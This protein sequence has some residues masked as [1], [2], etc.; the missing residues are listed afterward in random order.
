[1][2]HVG[3][4][5]ERSLQERSLRDAFADLFAR[6]AIAALG[7]RQSLESL[8]GGSSDPRVA[9]S[10]WDNCMQA[11]ICK[12]PAIAI[13]IIG[14]LII[15]SIVWCIAR[16]LCCGLSCCCECCYCLKC[17]GECCGCCDPPRGKRNKYLDEPFVPPHHEPNQA[18]HSQ[19]PMTPGLPTAPSPSVPQ[20]AVFDDGNKKDADALPAMPS[21]EDA[22]SQKVLVEEEPVEMEPLKKP[23]NVQN[24]NSFPMS[25]LPPHTTTPS[26][27][28][29]E[30]RNPY[31]PPP[32]QGGP[33]GYMAAARAG[34]DPYSTN[35]QGYDN[36]NG[37]NGY[38]Q[39]PQEDMNQGYGMAAGAMRTQ[40]PHRDYNNGYGRGGAEQGYPQSRTPRPYNDEY[41]RSASPASYGAPPSYRTAPSNNG[42]AN[43]SR[44]ASPGP[45]A[46]YS[47]GNGN[48]NGNG[49]G[50]PSRMRTPGPQP[51]YDYPQRSQTQTPN[52]YNRQYPPAPQR[53]YSND[54]T[55]PLVQ[56]AQ[57]QQY[58]DEQG[59]RSPIQNNSG[60][61]FNSG[62]S[63]SEAPPAQTQTQTQTANGGTAYPGYR[64]YRPQGQPQQDNWNGM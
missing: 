12:W 56:P 14:G 35:G 28:S 50:A 20:Y 5:M 41:G 57:D 2:P 46:G 45:Q 49:N 18:Y 19:A 48:G 33:N 7:K 53:Q 42:Y 13:I 32:A 52:S 22:K 17:C 39:A 36:Y 24:N 21:W 44:M 47:Y 16:C 3:I 37:Y 34:P 64:T 62:Y 59:Q 63:R 26:P 61:D 60:F 55:R 11:D 51:G 9:F 40:T 4:L 54:S 15:F 23:E 29:P 27:V 1:M 6:S 38:G 58:L 43:P 10:S 8:M 30:N 25:N 31:G